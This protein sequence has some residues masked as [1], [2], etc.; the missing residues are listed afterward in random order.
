[1]ALNVTFVVAVNDDQILANNFLASPCL[2]GTHTHQLLLQRGFTSASTAYNDAI[3]QAVNDIMVFAHQDILFPGTWIQDLVNEIARI[4]NRDP[5]WGVL[6]C[7]GETLHDNGR[8]YV[9]SPG[10]GFLGKPFIGG[11][12]VQTLDE[13]VLILRKSTGLGFDATLPNFHFYGTDICMAAVAEG[14]KC[15]AISALCIHNSQQNLVLPPDFYSCYRHVKRRWAK[16]MPIRSTCARITRFDT[17]VYARKIREAILRIRKKRVGA[18][19]VQD[20]RLVLREMEAA[21]LAGQDTNCD[22]AELV[23]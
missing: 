10:R 12:E 13:I 3:R 18:Q 20:G 16:F 7:Y 22:V 17:D 23:G 6:G 4:E 1:V 2:Q 8:G 11:A 21:L 5:R 14:L 9:Y 19:R 15:Y